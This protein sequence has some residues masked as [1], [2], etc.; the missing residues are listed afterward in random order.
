MNRYACRVR[1]AAGARRALRVEAA[2]Q[3][4]AALNLIKRGF[5]PTEIKAGDGARPGARLRRSA[6]GGRT[7][8][9]D[10]V[11]HA[12]MV[13]FTRSL[14]TMVRSGLPLAAVMRLLA[15]SASSPAVG[16][17]CRH[18]SG[19]IEA[20]S[21]FS[22]ALEDAP[23]GL[24]ASFIE[25]VR[26]GEEGGA[27]PEVLER[28]ADVFEADGER[29][30]V[31]TGA[32]RYPLMVGAALVTGSLVVAIVVMPRMAEFYLAEG[33]RLPWPTLVMMGTYRAVRDH[34]IV[35][36]AALSGAV[37][38]AAACVLHAGARRRVEAWSWRLPVIGSIRR[39]AFAA[40]FCH[41][42]ATFHSAGVPVGRILRILADAR[43]GSAPG[44]ALEE[45]WQAVNAGHPLARGLGSA[46]D[47]RRYFPPVLLHMVAMGEESG[48][49]DGL[50]RSC[51]R[52]HDL[53]TRTQTRRA[54]AYLE[55]MGTLLFGALVLLFGL[56]TFLPMWDLISIY[57]R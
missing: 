37:A 11:A 41:F 53:E 5:V 15:M 34:P 52:F 55:P 35:A 45:S 10:R 13:A 51:G 23:A 48:S 54:I 32:L 1:D 38:A 33:A 56:A 26:A 40:Q 25:A 3:Q 12:D 31:L 21:S 2:S 8:G 7:L 6:L 27:L 19:A 17:L 47:A 22:A 30:A 4:E 20:G 18:L 50:L 57:R 39:Q 28:L 9:K 42:V 43:R 14:A 44:R 36:G 24:P 16:S 49:L 46:R 29:R